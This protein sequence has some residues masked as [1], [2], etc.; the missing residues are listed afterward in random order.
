MR[1]D[2]ATHF[3]IPHNFWGF[4]ISLFSSLSYCNKNVAKIVNFLFFFF[5]YKWPHKK[6]RNVYVIVNQLTHLSKIVNFSFVFFVLEWM[7]PLFLDH[8]CPRDERARDVLRLFRNPMP[9][10]K[11]FRYCVHLICKIEFVLMCQMTPHK[12]KQARKSVSTRK[13]T[14][15]DTKH[16]LESVWNVFSENIV[17][18][19]F[20]IFNGCRLHNTNRPAKAGWFDLIWCWFYNSVHFLCASKPEGAK[21]RKNNALTHEWWEIKIDFDCAFF[22]TTQAQ[23]KSV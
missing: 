21:E 19:K 2:L 13:K 1:V 20:F 5:L 12:N 18:W 6:S 10:M 3:D 23:R 15:T 4:S 8:M 7:V 22:N 9:N 16:E 14:S 11:F 17:E